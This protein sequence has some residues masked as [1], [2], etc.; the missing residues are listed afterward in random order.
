M[1]MVG[2]GETFSDDHVNVVMR[3]MDSGDAS[4]CKFPKYCRLLVFKGF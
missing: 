1:T 4:V 3:V 2:D